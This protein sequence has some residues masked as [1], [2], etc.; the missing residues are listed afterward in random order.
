MNLFDGQS[1]LITGGTGS[2]GSVFVKTVLDQ[3]NVKRIII[4][5]RDELKQWEMNQQFAGEQRLR[6][7]LGDVRDRQRL[8]RAMDGV[9]YV[10]HAAALKQVP[11]AEYNPFE[12]VQTNILGARNVIRYSCRHS[13]S[14]NGPSVWMCSGS[15]QAAPWASITSRRAGNVTMKLT[16]DGK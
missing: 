10:V 15:V 1:V 4:F 3:T 11:A 6:F 8:L 14:A 12:A 7:F 13:S 5:S 2:F 16:R 9:D